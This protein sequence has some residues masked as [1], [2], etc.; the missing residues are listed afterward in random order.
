MSLIV[1]YRLRLMLLIYICGNIL[2]L[3]RILVYYLIILRR[4]YW[5]LYFI[6]ID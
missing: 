4:Q 6:L 2:F 3:A 5:I 1:K